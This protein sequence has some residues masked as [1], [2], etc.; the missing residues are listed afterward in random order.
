V[1]PKVRKHLGADA[2]LRSVHDVFC[3]I[4]DSNSRRATKPSNQRALPV[5]FV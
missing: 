1:V 4:P 2:L 3:H 5:A